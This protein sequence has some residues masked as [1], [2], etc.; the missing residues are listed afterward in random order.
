MRV[1]VMTRYANHERARRFMDDAVAAG[2][3]VTYDWTRSSGPDTELTIAECME[4]GDD[5]LSGV[6]QADLLVFLADSPEYCGSLIEFGYG[7]A[8]ARFVHP[9]DIW[10][11]APWRF[12]LFWRQR[13]VEVLELENTA[14][15][16]LGM[17]PV[18]EPREMELA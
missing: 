4:V 12:S 6:E 16:R 3:E 8:V 18:P 13:G 17:P 10:V 15:G 2:H 11:V 14:R 5:C 9:I 1:Y 7:L